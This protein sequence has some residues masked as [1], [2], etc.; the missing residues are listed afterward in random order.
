M[1]V[2]IAYDL[3]TDFTPPPG[4]PGEEAAKR[5]NRR[6]AVPDGAPDDFLEEYDSQATVDAIAAAIKGLGHAPRLLG[7]GRKFMERVLADPPELVFNIAEGFGTRSREAHVPAVL[8]M[9]GIPYTHSDPLTLAVTLDKAV[10]KRL[11]ATAGVPTPKFAVVSEAAQAGDLSLSLPVIAKPLWEGSSKGI[12]KSSRITERGGLERT[13]G[14]LIA[15]YGEPVLVEEFLPGAEFT[16]GI[17]GTGR[18][19]RVLGALE[20]VPRLAKPEEFVYS[21][22]VKRNWEVEV[23]Y[24]V[25]P[26]RPAE[27]LRDVERVALE[28]YRALDCRDVGRVDVR[29]DA[30]GRASFLE[31]NPL[32]GIHPVTGDLC[33]LARGAGVA[34]EELIGAILASARKRWGI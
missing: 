30:A 4:G 19:A 24:H 29:L 31:V 17:L 32:P 25:P 15:D 13:I 9:L 26:R 18:D 20:I 22:E 3:K 14:G 23:E 34:Y 10:A 2:G 5:S 12:R 11:A 8:E 28:A 27:V 33:I 1:D 7:G 16:V 6:R 21:L